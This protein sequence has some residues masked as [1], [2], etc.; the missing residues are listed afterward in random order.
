MLVCPKC[1]ERL[2]LENR[3]FKC[4]NHHCFD[5]SK[6]GYVNLSMSHK[7]DRGDD[8]EMVQART[9]FLNEGHYQPL[10]DT[11]ITLIPKDATNLLDC[12][13]GEGYYTNAIKQHHNELNIV[14]IDLSKSAIDHASKAKS[15]VQY[16]VCSLANLPIAFDQVDC[17]FSVFAPIDEQGF[18]DVLKDGGTFIKVGPASKHLLGLKEVLYDQVYYNEASKP[19]AKFELVDTQELTYEIQ[20]KNNQEIIDLF[21]MTPYYYKTSKFASDKLKQYEQLTTIISFEIQI[22]KK[23]ALKEI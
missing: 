6:R 8:L 18:Y 21:H 1:K 15:N 20:L 13:C 12:G 14:G 2:I 23:N 4:H 17:L 19:L 11:L 16:V 7:K 10:L 5:L 22:Y 9:R 3:S